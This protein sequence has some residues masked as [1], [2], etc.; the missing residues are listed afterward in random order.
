MG[1]KKTRLP[2]G[3]NRGAEL[4]LH[5]FRRGLDEKTA[6]ERANQGRVV[7]LAYFC[8]LNCRISKIGK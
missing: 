6:V 4:S 1:V 7:Y 2:M 8:C 3:K 5:L